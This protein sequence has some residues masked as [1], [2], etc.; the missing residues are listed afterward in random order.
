LKAAK[1]GQTVTLLTGKLS[2]NHGKCQNVSKELTTLNRY[3][4]TETGF[5]KSV[6]R[7]L[8]HVRKLSANSLAKHEVVEMRV[9]YLF[10]LKQ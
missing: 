4:V 8:C 10:L 3:V 5:N 2:E 7:I 6:I 9:T 1:F